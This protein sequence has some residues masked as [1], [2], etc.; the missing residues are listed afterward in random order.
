MKLVRLTVEQHESDISFLYPFKARQSNSLQ[1]QF[2]KTLD[3][4]NKT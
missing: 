2:N 1:S 4:L 3:A